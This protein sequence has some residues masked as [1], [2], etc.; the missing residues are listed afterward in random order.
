M[1]KMSKVILEG[2]IIVPDADI[3]TVKAELDNHIKL[4]RAEAGCL[5]FKVTQDS[6]NNSRFKVY[7][8]FVDRDSF[9]NHQVRAGESKWAFVTKNVV[10]HYKIT[11]VE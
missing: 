3:L 6:N 4:T 5:V 9:A 7:E 10:R 8:E 11:D 1:S 2:H